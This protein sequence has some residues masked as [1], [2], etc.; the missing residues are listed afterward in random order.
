VRFVVF[1]GPVV[2]ALAADDPAETDIRHLSQLVTRAHE[3]KLRIGAEGVRT[4]E[5]AARLR[6]L[7]VVAARGP[8]IAASATGDEVDELIAQHSH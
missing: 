7:G 1:A 4:H 2:D 5:Q 6:Q 8:F 3:L